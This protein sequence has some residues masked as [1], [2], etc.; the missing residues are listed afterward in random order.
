MAPTGADSKGQTYGDRLVET[1]ESASGAD[2]HYRGTS[3]SAPSCKSNSYVCKA[4]L[5]GALDCHFSFRSISLL[6]LVLYYFV[7]VV[8]AAAASGPVACIITFSRP[9]RSVQRLVTRR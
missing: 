1:E 9:S 8:A 3:L 6:I 5:W 4:L 7:V 2:L